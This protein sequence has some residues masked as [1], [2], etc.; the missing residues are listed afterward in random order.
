MKMLA[1]VFN[2]DEPRLTT[3]LHVHT[4]DFCNGNERFERYLTNYNL[5]D[6]YWG[7]IKK[8]YKYRSETVSIYD[9]LLEVF[10]DNFVFG[11]KSNLAKDSRLLLSS[12]RDSILYREFLGKI[13]D[14]VALDMGVENKLNQATIDEIIYDELFRFSDKKSSMNYRN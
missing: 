5:H 11:R 7:E 2:T 12:W 10:N 14:K 6:F 1:V 4:S 13:S 9:F 8:K 3:F